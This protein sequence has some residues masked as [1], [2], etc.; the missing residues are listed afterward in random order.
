MRTGI[1]GG[2]FDPIHIGHLHAGETAF[3]QAGLD[4]VLFIPAGRPWQKEGGSVSDP[5]H[6]LEMT[7]LGVDGVTGLEVDDREVLRDGPTY[8][9]DTLLSFPDEEELFLVVGADAAVGI[10]TWH[11]A[12]EVLERAGVLVVPRAGFDSRQVLETIP[13]CLFLD[14]G[15]LEVSGT[16]IRSRVR[17]GEPFRFL[18]TERVHAYITANDLYRQPSRDD[19]VEESSPME[20][21]S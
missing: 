11:R 7:R 21:S 17:A 15:I 8:S 4:R 13:E 10:H 9:V 6:R 3:H 12:P 5:K 20:E 1:L 16:E 14:M 18:V 19:M 2:T